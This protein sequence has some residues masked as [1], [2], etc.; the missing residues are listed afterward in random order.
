MEASISIATP[1]PPQGNSTF[2]LPSCWRSRRERQ[3]DG[4]WNVELP[5]G[6]RGVA[7]EIDASILTRGYTVHCDI[8]VGETTGPGHRPTLRP[9]DAGQRALIGQS[10]RGLDIYG[11]LE[12]SNVFSTRTGKRVRARGTG[13]SSRW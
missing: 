9:S 7:I 1:L 3:Q 6:G 8:A 10:E 5:C 12:T 2:H 4:R 13:Q 11:R